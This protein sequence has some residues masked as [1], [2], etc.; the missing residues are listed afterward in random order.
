[1]GIFSRKPATVEAQYAPQVMGEN[2]FSLNTAI[3]PRISRKEAMTVPSI[4]RARNLICGTIASIPLEYYNKKTGEVI[5]PPRWISQ[6]SKSQPSFVTMAW[7]VDSLLMYGVAYLLVEERYAEDGRPASFEWMANSRVTFTTD[8]NGIMITQYYVDGAP[9][10][11]S[12][13]ITIQGFDEGILERGAR[14]I[15]AA[16]DVELAAATNSA[17]PQPAGFLKNSG[18]D[19]PAAEVQGL[20]AA[21][22]R[23]R[24]NNSTAYLTSTLD[25]NPVSFSPKDMMYN[26]AIQNLSTQ[27]ARLCNVPAYYLSADQNTTM[28]YANVQDER[29]QFFALSLQ[30]YMEAVSRRFSMDDISTIGHEVKFCVGDTFLQQDPLTE[31]AVIEKL[32]SLG[33]ITTEQAMG[34]TDLSPNG[35]EGIS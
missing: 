12:D 18:A 24:Q 32:L 28:T 14:T 35:S 5:A 9:I 25:Y 3:M 31:L 10:A 16:V 1:M 34:M 15:K 8:I 23:A 26:E 11:M 20:I 7:I 6:L 4:A 33:L 29:K 13:I 30:P 2:I 17:N 22:K 27:I 19:L 21:W